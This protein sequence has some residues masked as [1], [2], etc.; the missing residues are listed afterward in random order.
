MHLHKKTKYM[1]DFLT[2]WHAN[3]FD[4]ERIPVAIAAIILCVVVGMI[5]GPMAGNANAFFWQFIDRMFG[6]LGDKMDKPSRPQA[7]LLFRGFLIAM[8]AI[9]IMALIGKGFESFVSEKPISGMTRT[10]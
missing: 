3:F 5:T 1:I 6:R 10:E 2:Q 4:P 8:L 9:F 7:D